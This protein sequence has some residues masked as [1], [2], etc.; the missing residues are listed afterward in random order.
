MWS[1]YMRRG[2][3]VM[4][5]VGSVS[6]SQVQTWQPLNPPSICVLSYDMGNIIV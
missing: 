3:E 4:Q 2:W 5:D 1:H 6:D